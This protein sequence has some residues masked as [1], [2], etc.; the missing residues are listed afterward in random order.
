MV[1]DVVEGVVTLTSASQRLSLFGAVRARFGDVLGRLRSG[2][3]VES[4]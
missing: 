1:R 4:N 3:N 2:L